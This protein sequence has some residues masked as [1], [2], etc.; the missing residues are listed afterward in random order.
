MPTKFSALA[1][2]FILN[3]VF[4]ST[5]FS[6]EV[7]KASEAEKVELTSE[8]Q[9]SDSSSSETNAPKPLN[10]TEDTATTPKPAENINLSDVVDEP[11]LKAVSPTIDEPQDAAENQANAT[12]DTVDV[13]TEE[14]P[15]PEAIAVKPEHAAQAPEA[16]EEAGTITEENSAP[17]VDDGLPFVIDEDP[18]TKAETPTTPTQA[19]IEEAPTLLRKPGLLSKISKRF[20]GVTVQSENT[21]LVL[22]GSEI[23]PG[24]ST[25]LTWTPGSSFF[26]LSDPTPVLAVHGKHAGPRL[27]LTAAVH[28][29]E[30]NGIEIVRQVLYSLK[31][32]E[33]SGTVI[34]VPIVNLQGF[35]R[36]SRYLSDRRDLNR[37]FP[38]N[39]RGSSASRIAHS[40]FEDIILKCEALLDLHTGSFH[41]TNLP[42]LRADLN[43]E[44]V[45]DLAKNMG[46]IVAVQSVGAKGSLRRAAVEAGIPA[47]TLEAGKPNELQQDEIDHGVK[48]VESLMDALGMIDRRRFWEIKEEPVYYRSRWVRARDGGI[49]FSSVHLGQRVK[50]G[51]VLGTV[52]DP[53]TNSKSEIQSPF[54]GRVIGMALNQVMHPGFAAF[55]IGLQSSAEV[56]AT[57][58]SDRDLESSTVMPNTETEASLDSNSETGT[59][60]QKSSLP[61]NEEDYEVL[62]DSE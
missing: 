46:A 41:R 9:K 4:A 5:S 44:R 51:D 12:A 35:R 7:A 59:N 6:E 39:E 58:E 16:S 2:V 22:L 14:S 18:I 53:I 57:Q 19:P 13:A 20:A 25:R 55:H 40:L 56:A 24:T 32:E 52:T 15:E 33:L 36:S 23:A 48:S 47:V 42:Q 54:K 61:A 38:G 43:Y 17:I 37:Y 21:P 11:A 34:G 28:G 29:D 30:L 27:C 26:G 8:A 1:S 49:L 10:E 62:E 45:K 60:T 50:E 3:I 31:P